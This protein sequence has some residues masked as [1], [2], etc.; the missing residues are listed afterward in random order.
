MLL[1]RVKRA[2]LQNLNEPQAQ[3]DA[4]GEMSQ[5]QIVNEPQAQVVVAVGQ[6]GQ[7]RIANGPKHYRN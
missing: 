3:A 2:K 4:S 6:M 5:L 7:L 1:L